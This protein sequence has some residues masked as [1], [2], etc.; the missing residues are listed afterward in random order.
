MGKLQWT[1]SV[2]I[3]LHK[4]ENDFIWQDYFSGFVWGLGNIRVSE[5]P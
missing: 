5:I 2:I 1:K 4:E 3:Y